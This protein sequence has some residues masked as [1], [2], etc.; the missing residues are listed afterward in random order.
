MANEDENLQLKKKAN[1]DNTLILKKRNKNA[2]KNN[3]YF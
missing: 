1:E 3:F 2:I